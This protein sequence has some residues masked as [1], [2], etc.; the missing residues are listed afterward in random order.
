MAAA[1]WK[2]VSR[3]EPCPVCGRADWCLLST[4]GAAAICPRVE[5]DR[6]AG[7]AGWLH[8]L[9]GDGPPRVR[10]LAL[11]A[12][13]PPAD[14][15]A[16][17]ERC[18]ASLPAVRL[19]GFARALGLSAGS[20]AALRVGWSGDHLAWTFPMTDPV[21]GRVVGVRL[22]RPDGSKFAVKGGRE[23]LFLPDSAPEASDRLLIA[24]GPTDT[25]A[26]LDLGFP[27]AVGRPSCTGG[28]KHLVA[29]VRLR[30]P[31]EVVIVADG[32]ET[33]RLGAS[34]LAS[35]LVCQVR[36]VR[37]VTPPAG[38]KDTRSW[39]QAGATLADVNELIRATPARQLEFR[40]REVRRGR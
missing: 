38:V 4:D 24:E 33:G 7:D 32:D 6:R 31:R 11:L 39:K 34:R 15:S 13:P 40:V 8:R 29:L 9:R 25:A 2:R 36:A 3:A 17:A 5:S 21:T 30:R 14:L 1:D 19:A 37:V 20:L 10:R 23:G 35:A 12:D 16:L 28:T 18:R 27:G 26:L 22:R